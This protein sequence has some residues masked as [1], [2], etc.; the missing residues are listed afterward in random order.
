MRG[1]LK[2]R[3]ARGLRF[4]VITGVVINQKLFKA[5]ILAEQQ[6]FMAGLAYPSF[7]DSVEENVKYLREF[8]EA[9]TETE[10]L[11]LDN[12]TVS[13]EKLQRL[14]ASDWAMTWAFGWAEYDSDSGED[15]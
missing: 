5:F 7:K 15:E 8:I 2:L 11:Q 3:F 9:G 6:R 13:L 10:R 4:L 1:Y 14:L 12:Y